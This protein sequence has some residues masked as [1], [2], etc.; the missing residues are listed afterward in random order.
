MSHSETRRK[1]WGGNSCLMKECDDPDSCQHPHQYAAHTRVSIH[2]IKPEHNL[3]RRTL[4]GIFAPLCIKLKQPTWMG[5]D[6]GGGAELSDV[7]LRVYKLKFHCGGCGDGCWLDRPRIR[8]FLPQPF[9][10]L[11]MEPHHELLVVK[12][13]WPKCWVP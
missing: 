11:A 3:E 2:W 4:M 12:H 5:W 1:T 13:D 9:A 7:H 10:L 8:P 6:W